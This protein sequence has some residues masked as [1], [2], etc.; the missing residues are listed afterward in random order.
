M[1]ARIDALAW[2]LL[3]YVCI[4]PFAAMLVA[5]LLEIFGGAK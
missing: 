3:P 5:L 2:L 1:K 4:A